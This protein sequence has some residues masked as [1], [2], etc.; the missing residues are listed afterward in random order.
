MK[1]TVKTMDAG[2]REFE[3]SDEVRSFESER[4]IFSTTILKGR[5]L[6]NSPFGF[7]IM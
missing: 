7:K 6:A 1:V 3:M 4:S 2:S 5:F